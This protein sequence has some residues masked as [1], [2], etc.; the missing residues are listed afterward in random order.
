MVKAE[1]FSRKKFL[2]GISTGFVFVF[3]LGFI[4]LRTSAFF[5]AN[6]SAWQA[7]IQ[8]SILFFT[9]V[10]ATSSAITQQ[11]SA[12]LFRISFIKEF[13]FKFIP[14]LLISFGVFYG[15]LYLLGSSAITS[16]HQ[17]LSGI[18]PGIIFLYVLVISYPEELIFRSIIPKAFAL[19]K[20]PQWLIT[21]VSVLIFAVYHWTIGRSFLTLIIYIPLGLL[22]TFIK[23]KFSPQTD[24]AN[25][26]THAAWDIALWG[27]LPH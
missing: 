14:S 25:A 17:A 8:T 23:N 20:W 9:F 15:L 27:F 12:N 1:K 13:F 7:Y 3:V 26:G 5:P 18:S 4:Y 6:T 16:I 22:F 11:I 2:L 10:F 19:A 24:M 21:I